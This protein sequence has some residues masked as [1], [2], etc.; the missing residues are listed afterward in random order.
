M[1]I[2]SSFQQALSVPNLLSRNFDL[3]GAQRIS[4]GPEGFFDLQPDFRKV[5]TNGELRECLPVRSVLRAF[6]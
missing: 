1:E 2:L 3:K 6:Q 4:N 5:S